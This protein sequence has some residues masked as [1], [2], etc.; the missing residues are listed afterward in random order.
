M[1][2][3]LVIPFYGVEKY[4][5]QCL[6]PLGQ[7]PETSCEIL[8]VDDCGQDRSA[9]IAAKYCR[10][11]RNARIILRKTNGGLSAA[12]NT[13]LDAATGEYV[14]FLDSDDIPVPENILA[15]ATRAKEQS[16]DIIKGSFA[17]Y[18]DKTEKQ[19]D[20][21]NVTGEGPC[22]GT[23]LFMSESSQG[24]YE[25]MV[26]QCLYRRSF[27][28]RHGLRMP[29]GLLFEDEL[30]TTPALLLAPRV[31][32]VPKKLLLYRQREGSI[33]R[34]FRKDIQWC[35]C[36]LQVCRGLREFNESHPTEAAALLNERIAR[37]ALSFGKNIAAYGLEGQ[38]RGEAIGFIRA[39][40]DEI[41]EL[42][43][44][45][46]SPLLRLQAWLLHRSPETFIRLYQIARNGL[47]SRP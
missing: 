13:G 18:Q 23:A 46:R 11:Q 39:H 37:I 14:F 15:L 27:L 2:L 22:P 8:L 32:C 35:D 3:S 9:E 28:E 12:R 5:G 16:L 47:G 29:E 1:L 6:E 41:R 38:V 24:S 33:M 43:G 10:E 7:L 17:Y 42:T 25:P 44:L 36:Y 21:P 34:G 20:G 30:F 26:W 19:T 4:I 31:A 45:T 40:R